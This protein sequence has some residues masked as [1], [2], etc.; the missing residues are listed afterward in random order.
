MWTTLGS[1]F[2]PDLA[3][4]KALVVISLYGINSAGASFRNHLVNCMINIG[5]LLF[6]AD[7]D[8]WFREETHMSDGAKYDA[9]FLLYMLMIAW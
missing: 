2:G 6:L 9:Y 8:L 7:P 5:Y 4:K 1:E 3:G